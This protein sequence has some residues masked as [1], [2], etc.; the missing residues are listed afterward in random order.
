MLRTDIK[1]RIASDKR[2]KIKTGQRS[3]KGFP[4]SLNY[5][6]IDNFPEL[7][8]AYG[9]KPD[10][11]IL[12]FPSNDIE[13]F[14]RTEYNS[15]GSNQAKKRTCDGQNCTHHIDETVNGI[16]YKA[17]QDSPCCCKEN[18][19]E[20]ELCVCY[21]SI[22]AFIAN[23][24]GIV[25]SPLCYYFE[26][27]SANTADNLYSEILK[28]W[29]MFGGK[30]VGIPFLLSVQMVAGKEAN[31]KFP[32]W[33]IQAIGTIQQLTLMAHDSII[34]T[35]PDTTKSISLTGKMPELLESGQEKASE[36]DVNLL[37]EL[38]NTM[39]DKMTKE[40]REELRA[41]IQAGITKDSCL[42][43]NEY[44]NSL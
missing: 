34:P 27:H 14:Y 4:Q 32:I 16:T 17:G 9:N 25:I 33:N 3:E 7:I 38:A 18:D 37:R 1:P 15:Y 5:F 20:K 31:K 41:A 12:F 42:Q 29:Q 30:L 21:M 6:N 13:N 44:L 10:K 39:R 19:N 22:K 26:S 40:S 35:N 23:M 11:L 43:W 2:G 28:T 8:A 36:S 24:E